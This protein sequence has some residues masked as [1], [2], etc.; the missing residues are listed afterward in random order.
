MKIVLELVIIIG[1]LEINL[2]MERIILINLTKIIKKILIDRKIKEETHLN[3]EITL[4]NPTPLKNF[5]KIKKIHLNNIKNNKTERF[6]KIHKIRIHS[7][8]KDRKGMSTTL[9]K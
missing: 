3:K 7:R 8:S 6:K 5:R 1:N 9:K 2:M 4:L